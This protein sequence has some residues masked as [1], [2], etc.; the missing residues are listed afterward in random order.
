M[1]DNIPE[2]IFAPQMLLK[3]NNIESELY[4]LFEADFRHD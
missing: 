1:H 4:E 3:L 2:K